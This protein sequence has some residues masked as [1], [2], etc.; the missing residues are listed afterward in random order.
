MKAWGGLWAVKPVLI[1]PACPRRSQIRLPA[2]FTWLSESTPGP[3]VLPSS[4]FPH[5]SRGFGYV[6]VSATNAIELQIFN[7]EVDTH[8]GLLLRRLT[9]ARTF[10]RRWPSWLEARAS[11]L[12]REGLDASTIRNRLL[13]EDGVYVKLRTIGFKQ[14]QQKK[15]ALGVDPRTPRLRGV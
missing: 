8:R 4:A 2:S 12:I 3:L 7:P 13:H 11:S 9:N 5:E 10:R 15:P 14:C 1:P 6:T